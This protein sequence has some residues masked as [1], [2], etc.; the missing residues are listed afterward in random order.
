[1]G[2]EGKFLV[3]LSLTESLHWWGHEILVTCIFDSY[4]EKASAILLGTA[5]S[6]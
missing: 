1:M 4:G 3:L 5:S 2:L 6:G